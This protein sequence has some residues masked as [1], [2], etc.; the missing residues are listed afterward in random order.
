MILDQ[1]AWLRG[2]GDRVHAEPDRFLCDGEAFSGFLGLLSRFVSVCG[3]EWW[4]CGG[5]VLCVAGR[6]G[7]TL[8]TEHDGRPL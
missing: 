8:R 5:E 4:R 1:K 6:S 7:L 3:V 2:R